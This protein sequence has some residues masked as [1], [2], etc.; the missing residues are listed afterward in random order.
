MNNVIMSYPATERFHTG[1]LVTLYDVPVSDCEGC[2]VTLARLFV[3]SDR[4]PAGVATNDC[5]P[6]GTVNVGVHGSFGVNVDLD[7]YYWWK[8]D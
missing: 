4:L 2:F 1:D 3:A 5:E 6:G 8:R 7:T